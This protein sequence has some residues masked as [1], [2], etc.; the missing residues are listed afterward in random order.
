MAQVLRGNFGPHAAAGS[1][2]TSP[3]AIPEAGK[4]QETASVAALNLSPKPGD[5]EGN[6]LLAEKALTEAK[7]AHPD[8]RWAVLPE[9]FVSG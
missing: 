9:L 3:I 4:A 7:T 6:L 2:V 8:L 5:F 1:P